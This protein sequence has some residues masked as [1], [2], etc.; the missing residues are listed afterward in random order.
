MTHCSLGEKS[1]SSKPSANP[2]LLYMCH[3]SLWYYLLPSYV[4]QNSELGW[5]FPPTASEEYYH[6][7]P[8]SSAGVR[9]IRRV[10]CLHIPLEKAHTFLAL[11]IGK[12]LLGKA[13][14]RASAL[15]KMPL[16]SGSLMGFWVHFRD[17]DAHY[18][19]FPW[20]LRRGGGQFLNHSFVN[21]LTMYLFNIYLLNTDTALGT[22][23]TVVN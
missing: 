22:G 7:V 9:N 6:I 12:R 19:D 4:S 3:D 5:E 8:S 10:F 1:H 16:S 23:N 17:Q 20:A 13:V 21:L 11:G 14:S 2:R 18:G 15:E